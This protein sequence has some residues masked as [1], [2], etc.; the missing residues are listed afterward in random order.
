MSVFVGFSSVILLPLPLKGWDSR[1][2]SGLHFFKKNVLDVAPWALPNA[3]PPNYLC[4]LAETPGMKGDLGDQVPGREAQR[5]VLKWKT[6]Q[7]RRG[8]KILNSLTPL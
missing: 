3:L 1:N 2:I 8:T 7:G 4:T 5:S 6:E